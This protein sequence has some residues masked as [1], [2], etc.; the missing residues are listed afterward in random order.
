L[1]YEKLSLVI[2]FLNLFKMNELQPLYQINPHE[3]DPRI[4]FKEEGH[5]YTVDGVEGNYISTTTF[6][7]TFF[8]HF[9]ADGA[10]VNMIC[11][12]ICSVLTSGEKKNNVEIYLGMNKEQIKNTIRKQWNDMSCNYKFCAGNYQGMSANEIKNKWETDCNIAS[13]QGTRMH[14]TIERYFN[15]ERIASD[16]DETTVEFS[17]FKNFLQEVVEIKNLKPYR[18]EWVVFD[19]IH[20]VCGS[21]DMVFEVEPGVV[22]IYDWKRSKEIKLENQWK[23]GNPPVQHLEDCNY[24]HYSLQLNLY[25]HMLETFYNKKVRDMVLVIMHPNQKN[26]KLF[27]VQR[28]EKEINDMLQTRV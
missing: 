18:S 25:R 9:D 22:D 7:H 10:I 1:K 28:M 4:S 8:E 5:V 14:A 26:Y 6:I 13:T 16:P 11:K 21:I 23:K 27:E 2:H 17:Y 20:K 3:R 12:D 15:N 19:D 24:N